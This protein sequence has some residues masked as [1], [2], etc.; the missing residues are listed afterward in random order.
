[1][2]NHNKSKPPVI[3]IASGKGGVGKT[4]LTLA[5]AYELGS[6]GNKVLLLDCDFYNRGLLELAKNYGHASQTFLDWDFQLHP[7][8]V[9]HDTSWRI[10]HL[11]SNT[12][13]IEIP[14]LDPERLRRLESLSPQQTKNFISDLTQAAILATGADVVILDCHGGRDAISFAA[15]AISDHLLVVSAPELSTF[16][17]TIQFIKDSGRR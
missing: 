16:F 2:T 17:G 7:E 15:A 11:G 12:S 5:L 8:T 3:S 13:T 6:A 1:M 10:L 14:A 4:T 9:F